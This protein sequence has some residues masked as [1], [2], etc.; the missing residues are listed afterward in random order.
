MVDYFILLLLVLLTKFKKSTTPVRCATAMTTRIGVTTTITTK[1][2]FTTSAAVNV[3][4]NYIAAT[5]I[6]I[7]TKEKE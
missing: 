5:T 1:V 3:T 4:T 2:A 6:V 7:T